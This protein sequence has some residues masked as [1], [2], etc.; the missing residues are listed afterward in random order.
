M[1]F[2]DVLLYL[3][4]LVNLAIVVGLILYKKDKSLFHLEPWYFFTTLFFIFIFAEQM[5]LLYSA[6]ILSSFY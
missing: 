6:V 5:L 3:S 1:P 4:I 2:S